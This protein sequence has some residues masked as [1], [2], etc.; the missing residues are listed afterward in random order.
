MILDDFRRVSRSMPCPVCGRADWCMV[1]RDDPPGRALCARVQSLDRWGDA[2]W[3]HRLVAAATRRPAGRMVRLDLPHDDAHQRR[4]ADAARR[5]RDRLTPDRRAA[6]AGELGV[7]ADALERLAVGWATGAELETLDTRC[8]SHGAWAFPMTD[9]GGN[10]VGVRL[11]SPEGFKWSVAGGRQGLFVPAYLPSAGRIDRLTVCE[12]P[13]DAAA[14]IDLGL[15]AIGRPSCDS[16]V[17][18]L[19]ALVQ[20][21]TPIDVL[22]MA[23]ADAP[24][25]RGA[26]SL[27]SVLCAYA[28]TVRI[29]TPP[30]PHKDVR[31]WRQA[32]ASPADVADLIDAAPVHRL[33]VRRGVARV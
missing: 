20:K 25:Q 16:G 32:G 30:A 14:L 8:R 2:G 28:P 19:S 13:T 17:K 4:I 1:S 7:T 3:L 11:R 26:A 15:S 31:A 29:I 9:A 33:T 24:G 10:V 27:A 22:I 23:D 18:L 5:W 6:L 21:L 12:G